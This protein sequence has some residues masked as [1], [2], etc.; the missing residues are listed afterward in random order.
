MWTSLNQLPIEEMWE[1]DRYWLKELLI[2]KM[3][4]TGRFQFDGEKM[5][6]GE[7]EWDV[8]NWG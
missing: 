7:M 2:E 4:F 3:R 1:D 8:K 5:E 6:T